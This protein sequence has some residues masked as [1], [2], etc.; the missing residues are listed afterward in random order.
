V[1]HFRPAA[2][3][4][5]RDNKKGKHVGHWI[6][7]IEYYLCTALDTNYIR[8]ASSYPVCGPRALLTNVYEAYKRANRGIEPPN[9]RDFFRQ[10]L[11]ANYGLQDLNQMY[12]GTPGTV[13][14][15]VLIKASQIITSISSRP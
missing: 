2:P 9:P 12:Y 8:L 7:V 11:E 1:D 3:P 10:T 15:W 6:L 14:G 4:Q 13:Y 5:Y